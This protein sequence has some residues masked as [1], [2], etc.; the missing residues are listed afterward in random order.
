MHN[1]QQRHVAV[2]FAVVVVITVQVDHR[3][4]ITTTAVRPTAAAVARDIAVV[5]LLEVHCAGR[6]IFGREVKLVHLDSGWYVKPSNIH[7][8]VK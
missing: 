5:N 4:C 1:I 2:V 6:W 3:R 7:G 8:I